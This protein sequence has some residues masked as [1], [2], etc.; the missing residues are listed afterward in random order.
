MHT[1]NKIFLDIDLKIEA[2]RMQYLLL[3][4][5]E[6][7][8]EKNVV[9]EE[10]KM[11]TESNPITKYMEEAA[12][13]ATYFF[14]NYSYPVIGYIDQIKACNAEELKKHYNRFYV[15]NNA[16][17]LLVGDITIEEAKK[18]VAKRFGAIP[19]GKEIKRN[20]IID[21]EN[22]GLTYT[23]DNES[24]QISVHNLNII[25]KLSRG[26][27]DNIK[28]SITVELVSGIL[29][30]GESSVLYQEIVEK[31]KLAHVLDSYVDIRAYDKGR[32]N[33]ATVFRENYT[34]TQIT[35]EINSIINDFSEKYLTRERFER[36]KNKFLDQIEML[37]DNPY[38]MTMFVITNIVN[39]YKLEDL[40]NIKNIIRNITFEEAKTMAEKI[41][42]K[43]NRI[44]KI[45]SHPETK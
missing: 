31:K 28:E 30:R 12:W 3:D 20:R 35:H 39:G 32:L 21:P 9:I 11:R 37:E 23:I 38:N 6:I 41:F 24:S 8:S 29:A 43:K 16:F 33:I 36:E 18:L 45:Y 19:K 44:M 2:D 26:L 27:I 1:C 40:K 17:I 4:E 25:Y 42:N 22:T 10:R 15:P 34:E 7:E 14:S 13:K 5:K